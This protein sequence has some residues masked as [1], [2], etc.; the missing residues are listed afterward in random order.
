MQDEDPIILISG[1]DLERAQNAMTWIAEFHPIP[2]LE[3]RGLIRGT[4]EHTVEPV[5][6]RHGLDGARIGIDE[7]SY[8]QV[9]GSRACSLK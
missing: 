6:R 5:L 1:G 4:L 9:Q 2:I 3:T 8:T 7:C